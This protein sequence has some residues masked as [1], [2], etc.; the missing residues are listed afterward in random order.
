MS[1]KIRNANWVILVILVGVVGF[2]SYLY[3]PNTPPGGRTATY[4]I[5][6]SDAP[7]SWKAQAD[8]ICD[9]IGDQSEINSAIK[10]LTS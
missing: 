7:D 6:A 10:A 4:F 9:G 5:A 8:Y 2:L 3:F 1:K